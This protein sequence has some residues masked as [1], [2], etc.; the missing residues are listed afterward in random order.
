MFILS[1]FCFTFHLMKNKT[2]S[3]DDS[4]VIVLGIVRATDAV[5][6]GQQLLSQKPLVAARRSLEVNT[7][8]ISAGN[9]PVRRLSLL[10]IIGAV[11]HRLA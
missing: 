10:L 1:I 11:L 8:R 9:A 3:I 4:I 5:L 2:K 7:S 6:V